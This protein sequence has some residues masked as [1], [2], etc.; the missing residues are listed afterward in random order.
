MAVY[1][2]SVVGKRHP[3]R[4]EELTGVGDPPAALRTVAAGPLCAVVSDAP[5]GLRAKRRDLGAHQQVQDALMGDGTVLP[6]RFGLLAPDDEAVRQ[7]LE[8][9]A[10]EYLD[11]LRA[12]EGCTE[13]N[14]KASQEEE[15]LLRQILD[16]SGEARR[17]NEEI[18]GGSAGPDAPMRLGEMV[19]AEVKARQEALAAGVV[20]A[21]RPF[22]R[23]QVQ[24]PP[25]GDDFLSVSFLVPADKEE[26]F[27]ATELSVANQLGEDL[28]FRLTGPLPPYSFV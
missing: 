22:S 3:A 19:A 16:S 17:L 9:R 24:S 23:D 8:E 5:D 7:A 21:L 25:G 18:R 14:L 12:L 4:V 27:L 26:L 10:D 13:Y 1:I 20:E 15:T 11:R 2:Y 28:D 6:L